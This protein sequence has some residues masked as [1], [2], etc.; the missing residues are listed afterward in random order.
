[1]QLSNSYEA[2]QTVFAGIA[3]PLQKYL[4][5]TRQQPR[6]SVEGIVAHIEQCLLYNLS[7]KAFLQTYL[8]QGKALT[9]SKQNW[10]LLSSVNVNSDICNGTEFCLQRGNVSLL[11][12]VV[13][14]PFFKLSED[15]SLFTTS[16]NKRPRLPQPNETCL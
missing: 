7:S 3:N 8:D 5:A 11:V 13:S 9:E 2:A 6:H 15:D 12:E 10:V 14:L 4:R 16:N 1:M